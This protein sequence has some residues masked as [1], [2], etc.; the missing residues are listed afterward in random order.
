MR[1]WGQGGGAEKE[2]S[3]KQGKMPRRCGGGSLQLWS[4][5]RSSSVHRPFV[6]RD[7]P[8]VVTSSTFCLSPWQGSRMV[9]QAPASGRCAASGSLAP[10]RRARQRC[11]AQGNRRPGIGLS[12]S[13]QWSLKPCKVWGA[14]LE[15][16]RLLGTLG[17][18]PEPSL[19]PPA[20]GA[21]SCTPRKCTHG[22]AHQWDYGDHLKCN[23]S[24]PEDPPDPDTGKAVRKGH[25]QSRKVPKAASWHCWHQRPSTVQKEKVHQR[26]RL[27]FRGAGQGL[28]LAPTRTT[29]SAAWHPVHLVGRG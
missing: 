1:L 19:L 22:A 27:F 20:L 21:P 29:H 23:S 16:K 2:P 18:W 24:S 9:L 7:L 8:E 11:R 26:C 25:R 14:R 10:G 15:G 5:R 3:R 4:S 12:P 6:L 17:L 13:A 28:I